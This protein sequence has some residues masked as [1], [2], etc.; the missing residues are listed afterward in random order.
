MIYDIKLSGQ[1]TRFFKH[2]PLEQQERVKDKFKEV[3]IDPF[4]FLEHFEGDYYKLRIG[5]LRALI[6]INFGR[7]L[8]FVRV[9]DKRGRVYK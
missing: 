1:A 4:G 9:L 6:D 5:Q 8:L 2:L 7:N 3:A